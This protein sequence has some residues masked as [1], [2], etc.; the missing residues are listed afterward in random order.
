M[1]NYARDAEFI[2]NLKV[3]DK[4]IIVTSRYG[5][6]TMEVGYVDKITPKRGDIVVGTK[7]FDKSGYS[8]GDSWFISY[9]TQPTNEL[10][11][12]INKKRC[13]NAVRDYLMDAL[14]HLDYN[15]AYDI[16]KKLDISIKEEQ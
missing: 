16:A 9:I 6:K 12:E 8:T 4:V 11:I 13:V 3:G 7:R 10:I 14:G 2:K 15:R 1:N 5:E